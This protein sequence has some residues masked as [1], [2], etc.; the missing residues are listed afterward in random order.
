MRR[1]PTGLKLLFCLL[2]FSAQAQPAPT[3]NPRN[4]SPSQLT[5]SAAGFLSVR[6]GRFI[7]AEGRQVLLHGLSVISKSKAENYQSWHGPVDFA[8]MR[9]WG[10]NCIRLGILWDGLEPQPGVF[11][12]GYLRAVDRRIAWAKAAGIH[13]F[14]DMH[15]DLYSYKYSDGAPEWATLTDDQPHVTGGDVWSDAYVSSPAIQRAFDN[16]WANKPCA[17]GAGVQDHFARAWQHVARRYA[18]E[19]TVIGFDLFNEPNIGSGNLAAQVAMAAVLA[20]ALPKVPGQPT[21]TAEDVARRWMD[22]DGRSQLMHVLTNL[23]I[24]RQVVDAAGP[25]FVDFERTKL[26]PMFQRVREAIRAVNTNHLIFLETSMS[27]NMG[28]PSGVELIRK[29]GGPPD[30]LQAYAPHGYDIVVDTPDVANASNDRVE[31]IFQR[32]A[33]KARQLGLPLLIGEWG[34]FG[35]AGAGILPTARHTAA[36]FERLR[37]SDTYWAYNRNLQNEVYFTT[38]QRPI[39]QSIAGTLLSYHGDP[40]AKTFTCVWRENGQSRAPTV[41]YLPQ[42]IYDGKESLRVEPAGAGF[43]IERTSPE[44]KNHRV[45]VF[46]IGQGAERRL[47]V[48]HPSA[49]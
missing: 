8:A 16:F 43:S 23:A 14:L 20:Q 25:V 42:W 27:A 38:L 18:H 24:Y 11:D 47:T 32:H 34:A 46:P 2:V 41:I 37:C 3:L 49:G 48:R 31:F 39:P 12:E 44:S 10:M 17:D 15:Q 45:T 28:I 33:E 9:D 13:V 19:P 5:T 26:M 4:S 36:L 35:N 6:D 30:P 40:E 22:R 1:I 7:D 29:Q 21:P